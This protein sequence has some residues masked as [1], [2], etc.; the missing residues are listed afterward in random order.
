VVSTTPPSPF[1][2]R[3]LIILIGVGLVSLGVALFLAAF[4]DDFNDKHTADTNGYSKSA[5]GYQGLLELLRESGIPTMD[6]QHDSPNRAKG[7]LLVVFAPELDAE[8]EELKTLIGKAPRVLLV[9][10]RW[11]GEPDDAHPGWITAR[12]ELDRTDVAAVYDQLDTTGAVDRVT[13]SIVGDNPLPSID[14]DIQVIDGD[15]EVTTEITVGDAMLLGKLDDGDTELWILADPSPLDNA[16]LRRPGNPEFAVAL[17]NR[18]RADGPV[19]FDE[20]VHGF[21]DTPSLWK[22]LFRFPLLL[23]SLHVILGCILILWAAVGRYGPPRAAGAAVPSGKDFLIR[24]TAELLH[25]GGHDADALRRYTQTTIHQTKVALHA[26]LDLDH[27]ALRTWLERIRADRGGTISI[28]ELEKDVWDVAHAKKS[29]ATA[30]R[31]VELSARV[32]RWRAEMTH[33]PQ[34]HP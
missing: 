26:P 33:G 30:R 6:S 16:G 12:Y 8:S 17:M 1:R 27:A 34:H 4:A 13:G 28:I 24:N 5:I 18:L 11:W 23:V 2:K 22:A 10:P 29:G 3:T 9:L 7:G 32:H 19:V 14:G 20:T 21:E 25:V 15:D 31:I